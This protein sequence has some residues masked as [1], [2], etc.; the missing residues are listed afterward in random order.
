MLQHIIKEIEMS[1][2]TNRFLLQVVNNTQQTKT[3]SEQF[4]KSFQ[5]QQKL[6]SIINDQIQVSKQ[7]SDSLEFTKEVL[8][9]RQ[10]AERFLEN[11]LRTIEIIQQFI[12]RDVLERE[13]EGLQILGELGWF[14]DPEM[15]FLLPQK[16]EVLIKKDPEEFSFQLSDYCVEHFREQL[17]DIEKNLIASYPHRSRQLR[18]AFNA[19]RRG[20]YSLSV[21][22]FLPEA[23]GIFG[24][25]FSGKSLFIYKQRESA[26]KEYAS[27]TRSSFLRKYYHILLLNLPLWTSKSERDESFSGLNRHKVLHG[28]S[29]DDYSEENSLKAISLLCFLRYLGL[30]D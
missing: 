19:H 2:N 7:A 30:H 25:I 6:A 20:E 26:I 18:E 12:G 24:E 17:D 14:F 8:A 13:K 21:K 9:S 11:R 4:V 1:L 5:E 23:D 22:A 29:L 16:I 27:K 10:S 3:V 28:E 15:P